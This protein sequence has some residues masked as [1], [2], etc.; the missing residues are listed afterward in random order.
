M[1][2]W[3]VVGGAIVLVAIV[4]LANSILSQFFFTYLV[5]EHLCGTIEVENLHT[6]ESV[7]QSAEMKPRF[8]EGLADAF[9][10]GA[11]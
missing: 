6:I 5:A 1:G 3:Q 11:V 10:V 4:Y 2:S 8:G 9:D 7:L